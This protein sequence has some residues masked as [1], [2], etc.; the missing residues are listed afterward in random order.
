[1]ANSLRRFIKKL[2]PTEIL[3]GTANTAKFVFES[4]AALKPEKGK[5]QVEELTSLVNHADFLLDMLN[6][7]LGEVVEKGGVPFVSLAARL[8]KFFT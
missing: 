2:T 7:P 5:P 1:M 8:L 6:S 3:D 4:A